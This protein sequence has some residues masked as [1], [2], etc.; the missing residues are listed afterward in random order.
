M[1]QTTKKKDVQIAIITEET[2]VLRSRTWDR[3]KFEVEYSLQKGTTAN[4]YLIQAEKTAVIDP[5]G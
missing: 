4:S 2:K 1:L 5:P 3:L